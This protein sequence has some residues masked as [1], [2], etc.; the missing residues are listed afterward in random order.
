M[1]VVVVQQPSSTTSVGVPLAAP[2]IIQVYAIRTPVGPDGNFTAGGLSPRHQMALSAISAAGIAAA[3]TTTAAA[4]AEEPA[5]GARDLLNVMVGVI[6]VDGLFTRRGVLA[7]PVAVTANGN[8][9]FAQ[10]TLQLGLSSYTYLQLR[11]FL[12]FHPSAI[13]HSLCKLCI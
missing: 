6:T 2:P 1:Q 4:S 7:N 8:L 13:H 10:L 3:G 12:A 9:T 5:P 11:T